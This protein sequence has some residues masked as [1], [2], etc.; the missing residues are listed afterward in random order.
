[1][2]REYDATIAEAPDI[3]KK[4]AEEKLVIAINAKREFDIIAKVK[5][6]MDLEI[7]NAKI[8]V[9]NLKEQLKILEADALEKYNKGDVFKVKSP[10][11]MKIKRSLMAEAIEAK[12]KAKKASDI[13]IDENAK[14]SSLLFKGEIVNKKYIKLSKKIH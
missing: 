5:E 13:Y 3:N 7:T 4:L 6:D 8:T 14:L 1:M 10:E 12:S 11:A 2:S 9:S